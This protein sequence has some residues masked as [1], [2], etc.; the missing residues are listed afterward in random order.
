ML[1]ASVPADQSMLASTIAAVDVVRL[2]R[3]LWYNPAPIVL[4]DGDGR[5][6]NDRA[7][8]ERREGVAACL[9]EGERR[10]AQHHQ[11][12]PCPGRCS[13]NPQTDAHQHRQH[14]RARHEEAAKIM[15][16]CRFRPGFPPAPPS[17]ESDAPSAMT[18]PTGALAARVSQRARAAVVCHG[19]G[20]STLVPRT[21]YF[22]AV[23]PK[24]CFDPHSPPQRIHNKPFSG[25]V[26]ASDPLV[27]PRSVPCRR[28]S[29]R[30]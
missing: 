11:N 16:A 20:G 10:T 1:V 17:N 7:V 26:D 13:P 23:V 21:N 22:V 15:S 4:E 9:Q 2:R 3:S 14:D 5:W 29:R 25:A 27:E 18:R 28:S 8:G 24:S 19:P 6:R 12:Q 30:R